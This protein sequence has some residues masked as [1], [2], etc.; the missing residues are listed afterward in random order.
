[1][2]RSSSNGEAASQYHRWR[3][4]YGYLTLARRYR[5]CIA[6]VGAVSTELVVKVS[7]QSLELGWHRRLLRLVGTFL[8]EEMWKR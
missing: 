2:A 3:C 5:G 8:G 6:V 7:G 1:M 4:P